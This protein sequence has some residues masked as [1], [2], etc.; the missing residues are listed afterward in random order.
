M[1]LSTKRAIGSIVATL[2]FEFYVFNFVPRNI[3]IIATRSVGKQIFD[4][5]L[6]FIIFFVV[7]YL[8][9]TLIAY[10][11]KLFSPKKK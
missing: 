7:A 3:N 1:F 8:V 6:N 11:I 2:V 10:L 9:L 5:I 4:Y